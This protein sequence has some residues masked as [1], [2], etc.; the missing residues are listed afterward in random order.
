M[1][2]FISVVL[3]VDVR[4]AG[5]AA[6]SGLAATG[7]GGPAGYSQKEAGVEHC[8]R[9]RMAERLAKLVQ[10]GLKT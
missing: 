5:I 4:R 3:T 8:P 7:A 10:A 1:Q 9:N 2:D 6:T